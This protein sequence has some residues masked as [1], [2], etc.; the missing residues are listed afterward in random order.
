MSNHDI[1][2]FT[3]NIDPKALHQVYEIAKSPAMSDAVI[4]IMPDVHAGAGCVIGFTAKNWK[5]IIAN[6]VGVDQGCG[7]ACAKLGAID[8]DYAKLDDVIAKHV[9]SGHD[10]HES[11]SDD[12]YTKV[13]SLLS[14]LIMPL[15]KPMDFF[16]NSIG[17]LG[18]GNHMIE[19]DVDSHG[20]KYLTIHT[21]SRNLGKLCCEY[22]QR[23]AIKSRQGFGEKSKALIEELK[24]QGRQSEI[25]QALKDLKASTVPIPDEMAYLDEKDGADYLH[26]LRIVQKYAILNRL[27]I[28]KTICKHMDWNWQK[29]YPDYFESIHNYIDFTDDTIRKGAISAR[30]HEKVIIPLNMRDGCILGYG[31]GN[32]EW[33]ESAPHG[34]G[35]IMSRSQAKETV[36]LQAYQDTM[37]DI[38]TTSVTESTKDE[39]PFAY[40]PAQEII[41]AIR[42][43]VEITDII[44]PV[45]NFKAH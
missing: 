2:I 11:Q 1:Q 3:E 10:I 17:T 40:K 22:Y 34:A 45:Y 32:P 31:K 28:A 6:V 33:N 27:T 14:K 39:S 26:D 4:R 42:D 5:N 7:V 12:I 37:K 38:Y 18:G 25:E 8:I 30:I 13:E 15:P 35:R 16:V 44:K 19:V 9:P 24:H 36:D 23:K 20:V 41:D 43:T 29:I 21:G